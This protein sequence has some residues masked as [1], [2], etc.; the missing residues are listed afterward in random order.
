MF[1][2]D[3]YASKGQQAFDN[4]FEE[5]VQGG[6][7][8][9][10]LTNEY[11][12]EYDP[13]NDKPAHLLQGDRRRRP[14]GVLGPERQALRQV[15]RQVVHRHHRHVARLLPRRSTARSHRVARRALKTWYDWYTPD[16]VRIAEYYEL[17][18][19]AGL[20]RIFQHK[21]TGEERREWAADLSAQDIADLRRP[22]AGRRSAPGAASASR[23]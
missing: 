2:A 11:E 17:E 5:A 10:R 12:D 18:D 13:E 1:R 9:W 3:V 23:S 21:A 4:A 16:V 19:R 20:L 6:M 15:G 8:A 14:V 22:R 7:G